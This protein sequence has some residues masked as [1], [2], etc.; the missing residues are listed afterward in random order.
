M[1]VVVFAIIY[2]L[3][4]ACVQKKVNQKKSPQKNESAFNVDFN[5]VNR[6]YSQ[7]KRSLVSDFYTKNLDTNRFSGMFLVAKN[8]QI[9]FEKYNGYANLEKKQKINSNT[10]VHIASISKVATSL[11]LLRLVGQGSLNLDDDILGESYRSQVA[12]EFGTYNL[13]QGSGS[14]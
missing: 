3:F 11:A 9:I 2:L 13:N 12:K 7:E 1:K 14:R 4:A 8:G 6:K 5:K 10:A